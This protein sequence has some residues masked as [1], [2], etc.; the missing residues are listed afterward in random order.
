MVPLKHPQ[1]SQSLKEFYL[2]FDI[3]TVSQK[4]SKA[5]LKNT[6]LYRII[7]HH[8]AILN[9]HDNKRFLRQV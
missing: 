8:E 5:F 2:E 3:C 7:D 6:F 1:I 4:I 9:Q